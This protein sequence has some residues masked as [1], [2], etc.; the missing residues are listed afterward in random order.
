MNKEIYFLT[1]EDLFYLMITTL[2]QHNIHP[3]RFSYHELKDYGNEIVKIGKEKGIC[4][5]LSLSRDET[6]KFLNDHSDLIKEDIVYVAYRGIKLTRRLSNDEIK[7]EFCSYFPL[8]PLL[9]IFDE[10]FTKKIAYKYKKEHGLIKSNEEPMYQNRT[11][12][13][14]YG[15][16]FCCMALNLYDEMY[17]DKISFE[18]L[19]KYGKLLVKF[20]KQEKI[21]ITLNLSLTDTKRFLLENDVEVFGM[22]FDSEEASLIF[23][24]PVL[25]SEIEHN[26]LK[27][28][29]YYV[30]DLIT[31]PKFQKK[32]LSMYKK[33]HES[34]GYQRTRIIKEE[35][36]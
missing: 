11:A 18:D 24:R 7:K 13:L 10:N 1:I 5:C 6:T 17:V 22:Y 30:K 33:E 12:A 31:D 28:L 32:V 3:N 26:F 34:N 19:N 29:R 8:S 20:A 36:L 9:T 27:Y 23:K 15:D 14:N 25:K 4:F 16:L 35:G 2:R 21:D